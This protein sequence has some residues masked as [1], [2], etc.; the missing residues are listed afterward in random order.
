MCI[1]DS[2]QEAQSYLLHELDKKQAETSGDQTD[3]AMSEEEEELQLGDTATMRLENG[4]VVN[5]P[6]EHLE[7]REPESEAEENASMT[8]RER[9]EKRTVDGMIHDRSMTYDAKK[10]CILSFTFQE[11]GVLNSPTG[12]SGMRAKK[13]LQTLEARWWDNQ[14]GRRNIETVSYTHLTLPTKLEV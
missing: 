2:K 10:A 8:A 3:V 12:R 4:E 7:P 9:S 1:R 13:H 6:M 11:L 14:E 5:I